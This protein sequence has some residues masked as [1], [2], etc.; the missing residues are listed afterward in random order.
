[1]ADAEGVEGVFVTADGGV[2]F[3]GRAGAPSVRRW[4]EELL[5]GFDADYSVTLVDEAEWT[6]SPAGTEFALACAECGNTVDSEGESARL[7]GDVYHFC[8]PSCRDQFES[9]YRRL[10]E[11]A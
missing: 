10:E 1:V 9:Q 7:G 4:V 8:C 6:R 3:V 2:W 11:D 5:D